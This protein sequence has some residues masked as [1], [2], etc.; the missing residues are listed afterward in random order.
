MIAGLAI[1]VFLFLALC[2]ADGVTAAKRR[3][4]DSFPEDEW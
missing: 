3:L 1:L 2:M 4:R